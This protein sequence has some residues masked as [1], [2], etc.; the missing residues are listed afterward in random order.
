VTTEATDINTALD[1]TYLLFFAEDQHYISN[2]HGNS[3]L[4]VISVPGDANTLFCPLLAL[5]THGTLTCRQEGTHTHKITYKHSYIHAYIHL[6]KE[7]LF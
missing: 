5:H 6:L 1:F 3:Q 4:S 7:K 2:P